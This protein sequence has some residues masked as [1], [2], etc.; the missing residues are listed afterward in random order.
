MNNP[1]ISIL[2]PVFNEEKYI[3]EAI[4]SVIYQTYSNF[5]LIIIDDGSIDKTA[6]IVK[7]YSDSRIQ[8]YQPG[9]IGKVAAFNLGFSKSRNIAV[10][11]A[12]YDWIV[13]NDHDDIMMIY[14]NDTSYLY[15]TD[16]S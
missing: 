7:K 12:N 1:R 14:I 4:E 6:E 15:I 8:F 16:I 13:I 10:K 2:M 9:K 5:E 3:S 11:L